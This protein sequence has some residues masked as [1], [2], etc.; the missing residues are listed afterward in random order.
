MKGFVLIVLAA[1]LALGVAACEKEP[2]L[3]QDEAVCGV[4]K[5]PVPA[6]QDQV[7]T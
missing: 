7:K 1:L 3:W 4:C 2:S 5:G 6:R